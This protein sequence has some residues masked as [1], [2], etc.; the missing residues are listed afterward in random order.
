MP[1]EE[2][3]RERERGC[4]WL[5]IPSPLLP[6][7]QGNHLHGS[8]SDNLSGV[9]LEAPGSFTSRDKNPWSFVPSSIHP[10]CLSPFIQACCSH[11]VCHYQ[12]PQEAA[13]S[14]CHIPDLVLD[15]PCIHFISSC[16]LQASLEIKLCWQH[17][18][19]AR[20]WSG[21]ESSSRSSPVF[22]LC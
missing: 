7:L 11:P 8:Y 5:H 18:V 6:W 15:H 3:E 1:W 22:L 2:W 10:L 17:V 9:S 13:R 14:C 20:A 4:T 21:S 16:S 19:W 12:T